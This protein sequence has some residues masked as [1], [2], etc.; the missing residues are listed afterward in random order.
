M[1][2]LSQQ[3]DP[4]WIDHYPDPGKKTETVAWLPAT[5]SFVVALL[6]FCG[7]QIYSLLVGSWRWSVSGVIVLFV[8]LLVGSCFQSYAN[9]RK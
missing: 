1:V 8:G 4:E 2:N 3:N 9:R 7:L 6:A 5:L